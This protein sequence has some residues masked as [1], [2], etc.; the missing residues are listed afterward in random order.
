MTVYGGW[1]TDGLSAHLSGATIKAMLVTSAYTPDPDA[2]TA[3]SGSE[4]SGT[5]YTAGGVD[6]TSLVSVIYDS[7]AN[8]V[9]F[10]LSAVVNF[11]PIV[12]TGIAGIVLY[13]SGGKPIVVDMFGSMDWDGSADFT[14]AAASGGIMAVQVA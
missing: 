13:V 2:T 9:Q 6:V 3:P 10:T 1:I 12:A 14:Y 7:T 8:Q 5:G 11:G 4:I